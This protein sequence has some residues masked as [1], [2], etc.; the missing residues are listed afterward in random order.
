MWEPILCKVII[1]L[2]SVFQTTLV[3]ILPIIVVNDDKIL[4]TNSLEQFETYS[5]LKVLHIFFSLP[6]VKIPTYMILYFDM[7]V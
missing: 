7:E 4:E 2:T 5:V 1:L 6:C 3:C